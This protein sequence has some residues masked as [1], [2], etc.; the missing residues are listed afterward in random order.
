MSNADGYREVIRYA[1]ISIPYILFKVNSEGIAFCFYPFQLDLLPSEQKIISFS[2]TGETYK[3]LEPVSSMFG[4]L[5]KERA[6]LK[7]SLVTMYLL[8]GRI[9]QQRKEVSGYMVSSRS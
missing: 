4:H 3:S 9:L 6:P 8:G 7:N 5:E 1:Y 2:E